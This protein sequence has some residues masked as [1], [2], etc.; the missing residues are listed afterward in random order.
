MA[1]CPV[2]HVENGHDPECSVL[3][4]R[5]AAEYVYDMSLDCVFQDRTG[6]HCIVNGA[7]FGSWACREYA[8]AGFQVEQR[9]AERR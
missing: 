9:R 3:R 1:T 4:A 2:C 5:R 8:V 7:V 6:W